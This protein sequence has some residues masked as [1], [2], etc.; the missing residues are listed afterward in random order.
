MNVHA[1]NATVQQPMTREQAF[2]GYPFRTNEGPEAQHYYFDGHFTPEQITDLYYEVYPDHRP[3]QVVPHTVDCDT[4]RTAWA[5]FTAHADYCYLTTGD[6]DEDGPLDPD[7]HY[8]LCTCPAQSNDELGTGWEHREIR[9]ATT[10]IPGALPVTWVTVRP[11][12][13]VTAGGAR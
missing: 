11:L 8:D 1:T 13:L 4:V 10:A 2:A 12:H 3:G 5:V 9:E 6:D 7:L